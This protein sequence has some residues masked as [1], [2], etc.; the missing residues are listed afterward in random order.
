MYRVDT[1]EHICV[2]TKSKVARNGK[3]PLQSCK[4][5]LIQEL[6]KWSR[7]K[8]PMRP[9]VHQY[10]YIDGVDSFLVEWNVH[11]FIALAK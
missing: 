2:Q 10:L 6:K 5:V 4:R 9:G 7:E 11:C 8:N 3:A 1:R